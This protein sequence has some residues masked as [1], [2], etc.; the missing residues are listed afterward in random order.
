MDKVEWIDIIDSSTFTFEL[1]PQDGGYPFVYWWED[2]RSS[3]VEELV[4]EAYQR[5]LEEGIKRAT[6]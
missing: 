4:K 6:K 1:D 3:G 2:M 5:G